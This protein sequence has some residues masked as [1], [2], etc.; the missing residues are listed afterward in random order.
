M[1]RR[2]ADR[3][4]CRALVVIEQSAQARSAANCTNAASR[5][6]IDERVPESLMIPFE[7][8]VLYKLAHRTPKMALAQWNDPIEAFF[9]DRSHK[10]LGVRIRVWCPI[11]R[12]DDADPGLVQ[13]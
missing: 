8:V 3:G 12:L 11:R 10:S 7:M 13:H 1:S 4:S 6:T 2:S 5:C 9:F